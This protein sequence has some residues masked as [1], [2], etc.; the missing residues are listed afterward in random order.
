MAKLIKGLLHLYQLNI[1]H[2]D[3]KLANIMLHFP[4]KGEGLVVEGHTYSEMDLISMNQRQKI[5]FLAHVDLLQVKF[6][7]KIADFGFS[8]YLDSKNEKS[9]TMCGTPLYMSPQIV[10]EIRYTY[11]TD[12]WSLGVVFYEL[13]TGRFPFHGDRMA[14]LE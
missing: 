4:V 5:D 14:Q 12:I 9:E 2:R 3:L 11:K 8:K 6:E 13:L 7:V 10:D 1:V